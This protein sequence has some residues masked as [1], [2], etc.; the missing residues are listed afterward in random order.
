MNKDGIASTL[1]L[2]PYTGAW[3]FSQAAHLL[4]RTMFGA[5]AKDIAAIQKLTMTQAVDMLLADQPA[6]SDQPLV[7]YHIESGGVVD[8]QTWV[9]LDY[10]NVNDFNRS[11]SLV[12]W[13]MNLLLTQ[14]ISIREKM[15]LFWHNHFSCGIA[16]VSDARYIY[17]QNLLM[18]ANA[19]GNFKSLAKAV[20]LDPAMLRY[21]S[22]NQNIASAPNENYGRELQEL[23]TIGKG[24]EV[25]T[26]D[27]TTYTEADVKAAAHVLTGWKDD[28]TTVAPVF[29]AKDHDPS[30]KKFSSRYGNKVIKGAS[31]QAGAE[32]EIDDL[33]SMIFSET[34]TAQYICRKIFRWFVDYK[35]DITNTIEQDVIVPLAQTLISNNFEIK[36]VLSQ[37]LKSSLFYDPTY[38]GCIIKAPLDLVVG[39][40]RTLG[41]QL[42]FLDNITSKYY[43]WI[44]L[45]ETAANLQQSLLEPPNV[46]GWPEYYEAPLYHE[47]W[48]NSGT[49]D[50]RI[51]FVDDIVTNKYSMVIQT[52][53]TSNLDLIQL[54]MQTSDPSNPVTLISDLVNLM[55]PNPLSADQMTTLHSQLLPGLPDYEWTNEW[56]AYT[57]DPKNTTKIAAVST[58]LAV[59]L[60]YMV[61]LAEYQLM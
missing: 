29:T 40:V 27:Y 44:T 23:F 20:T 50:S 61:E 11:Q 57:Q 14:N 42:P 8:G 31:D 21:L 35:I 22:G 55:Y 26:G 6:P 19:L 39:M 33:L 49:L 7:W 51:K 60:K 58:K 25:S 32:R 10:N 43:D 37:L 54:A 16:T 46:A 4:R 30:D 9:N 5:T 52:Y 36:P 45:R 1:P 3:E 56:T 47:L 13:Y 24:P 48:I 41:V 53:N 28:P 38:I 18:R 15:T 59:L 34:A 12:G 2:D 17:K